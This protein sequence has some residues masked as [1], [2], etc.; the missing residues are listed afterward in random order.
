MIVVDS[1]ALIA[2]LEKEPEVEQLLSIICEA[3]RCLV[4]AVTVYETGKLMGFLIEFGV[5][6]VPFSEPYISLALD[7]YARYGKGIHSKAA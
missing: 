3:P 4:S 5:E 1:S 6:V 2:T 7:A